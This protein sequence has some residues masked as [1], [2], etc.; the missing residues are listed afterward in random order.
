MLTNRLATLEGRASGL[1]EVV[2]LLE[3]VRREVTEVEQTDQ[4]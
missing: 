4:Q 3:T 1:D 2:D